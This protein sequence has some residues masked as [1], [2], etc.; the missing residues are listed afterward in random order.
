[1]LSEDPRLSN[2]DVKCRLLASAKSSVGELDYNYSVFQ[3]G[4]GLVDAI[5]ALKENKKGVCQLGP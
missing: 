4:A 3:Q 5:S 2:D 1:M